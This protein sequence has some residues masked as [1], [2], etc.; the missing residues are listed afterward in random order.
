MSNCSRRKFIKST[1]MLGAATLV[2]CRSSAD[3]VA[4]SR[5]F[6]AE[7]AAANAPAVAVAGKV[8]TAVLGKTGVHVPI[9]SHG[10][11]YDLNNIMV[12]RAFEL[13]INYFDTA[14]C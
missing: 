4:D 13:G 7:T 10:G 3:E 11:T 5:V 2:G 1:M 9:L 14:D 12:G 6:P 8:P